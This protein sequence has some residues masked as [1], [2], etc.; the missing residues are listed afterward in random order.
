M[1]FFKFI[2]RLLTAYD[3]FSFGA[4][5]LKR[6]ERRHN[7]DI[8][9]LNDIDFDEKFDSILDEYIN[10]DATIFKEKL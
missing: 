8:L 9:E 7:M 4:Y 6:T 2:S 10:S 3:I 1:D 5:V